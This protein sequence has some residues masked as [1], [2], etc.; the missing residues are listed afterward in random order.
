MNQ[1]TSTNKYLQYKYDY[2]S[3]TNSVFAHNCKE[4]NDLYQKTL[5]TS[6]TKNRTQRD[7]ESVP[8]ASNIMPGK[9]L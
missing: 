9:L 8:S 3:Q 2:D 1:I 6:T 4:W 7:R 5:Q